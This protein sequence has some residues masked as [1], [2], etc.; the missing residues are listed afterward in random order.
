MAKKYWINVAC[1]EG[2]Q[3]TL[4][5]LH[6]CPVKF[7]GETVSVN[8][9]SEYIGTEVL[10]LGNLATMDLADLNLGGL[11]LLDLADLNLGGL[12]HANAG[13]AVADSTAEQLANLVSDY[14]LLLAS[15]RAAGII[16]TSQGQ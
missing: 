11:A 3:F 16:A 10:G 7:S 9:I 4:A 15:L 2:D 5:R 12:A 8:D 6:E 1:V 13:V 14:N